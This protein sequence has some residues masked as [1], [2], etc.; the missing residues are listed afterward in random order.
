[1]TCMLA[2]TKVLEMIDNCCAIGRSLKSIL[3]LANR[4]D[5]KEFWT[6][7]KHLDGK[8]QIQYRK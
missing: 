5:T 6:E 2:V 4:T 8:K 1:M 3:K 7:S